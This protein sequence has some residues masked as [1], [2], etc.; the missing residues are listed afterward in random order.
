MKNTFYILI[1]AII[2]SCSKSNEYN[3]EKYFEHIN[4]AELAICTENF[5]KSLSEYELA[6]GL[7]EKPFG[8]DIFNSAL[9]SQLI[10]DYEKRNNFLQQII[11]NSEEL[12][13]VKSVFVGTYM[14]TDQWRE[15][16]S[17][18]ELKYDKALRIE[19][20]EI[21][22]RDQL[23]RPMY[24]THDDTINANRKINLKRI[25]ELT[26]SN[27]FPSQVELGYSNYLRNQPHD[28]VLHHTAQR[29]SYDKTVIDLEPVLKTAIKNGRFDPEQ[30]IFYLNFQNDI[31]KGKFE[32]Y[33]SWQYKHPLL[34]D[35]LNNKVW[36]PKLNEQQLTKV[37]DKRKEWYANSISDIKTKANFLNKSGLPFIFSSVKKSIGNMPNDFDK[38]KALEQ[39]EMMTSFMIEK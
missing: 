35:S 20:N 11:D 28:I 24:E 25:M 14:T 12:D 1:F 30:A 34:P 23:F 37:N 10:N 36:F 15:L 8:K 18:K 13:F 32:V 21:H 22:N 3:S 6:F 5:E 16:V 27:G 17:K 26:D 7:I 29:R 4:K 38:E 31:E 39:Y 9:S 2:V 19:F 33:S